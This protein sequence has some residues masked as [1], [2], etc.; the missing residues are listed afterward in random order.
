LAAVQALR[1]Q[2]LPAMLAAAV[3]GVSGRTVR[4]WQG[5]AR[6]A[7]PLVRTYPRGLRRPVAPE[8]ATAAQQLVRELHGLIGAEAL[9]QSVPGISRREAATVKQA[10]LIELEQARRQ[11]ATRIEITQPGVVRG[12]DGLHV[13]TTE[14]AQ[15]LLVVADGCIPY[16]TSST[17]TPRYDG[18]AVAT[19][20][21]RDF[22]THGAPLICRLD[23][24]GAHRV[25]LVR[26]VLAAHRVLV[27][28]GPPHYPSFYGQL[29]R[30]NRE[31]RQWLERL[32]RCAPAVLGGVSQVMIG[33]LN[34]RW[35]RRRL[36]WATAAEVW[37]H[38]RPLVVDR[39][40]LAAEVY[41]RSHRLASELAGRGDVA[42][43]AT[44]LAIEQALINRGLL[45]RVVGG[46]C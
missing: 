35:R 36:A 37:Q 42:I 23:R 34:T 44:R 33:V 12:L 30:Q 10:T 17:V 5:R 14:R 21:E 26:E 8:R 15:H 1:Q 41:E 9:R 4:R 25:G 39:T 24:A 45:R 22:R 7:E 29:E 2:G 20:L 3:V 13:A 43:L 40:E 6:R 18:V 31:H 32:G 19:L 28:H 27:L 16:R 46:W 38:R 11:Q